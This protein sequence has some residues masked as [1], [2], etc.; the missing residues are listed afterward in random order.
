LKTSDQA[1]SRQ[2][3]WCLAFF[4]A[5]LLRVL[6]ALAQPPR[7]QNQGAAASGMGNAFAAQADDASALYY[8]PAGMTQL[9]G[10]QFMSGSVFVGG[11]TNFTSPTGAEVT[12]DRGGSV[13]WPPPTHAYLIANLKDLGITLLGD[14]TVGIGVTVPFG[15]LIRYPENGPF[16]TAVTFATNPLL[17]I[18]PTIAYKL[19]DYLS[20]GLGADI[21]TYASLFGEGQVEQISICSPTCAAITGTPVGSKVELFGKDTAAGFNVSMMYTPLRNEDRLPIAN[22]GLVYRSQA[23][24]HLTGGFLSNGALVSDARATFVLPQIYSG[25]IAIWPIRNRE[26][27]WKLELDV[28]YVGWKS[29]RNLDVIL[30]T[31]ARIP[32]DQ[33]WT[34]A[35]TVMVGT[36]YKWLNLERMPGWVVALRGGYMNQQT[37]I[38][39]RT[40]NPAIASANAHIPSFGLGFLCKEAGSVLGLFKCGEVGIGAIKTKAIGLDLSYNA[41]LYETRTIAANLNPTVNGTYQSYV[42]SGGVTLRVNF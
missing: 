41:I 27:E 7:I 11:T 19:N 4:L 13:A 32:Q 3:F 39:D 23:T 33:Q 9:H 5:V 29:V 24:L 15:V 12:G 10:I 16:R 6:P 28:D 35:Y 2:F 8:N 26:R 25:A 1:A 37:Q 42:H 36:E 17:D 40:F 18:K 38:P 20:F 22:I 30:A 14:T 34:N 31:G 21:Y